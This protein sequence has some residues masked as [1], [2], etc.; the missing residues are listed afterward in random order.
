MGLIT[1]IRKK[2]KEHEAKNLQPVLINKE[3]HPS[4]P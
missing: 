4:R 2:I 1:E 3:M